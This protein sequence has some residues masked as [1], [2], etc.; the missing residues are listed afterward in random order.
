[1]AKHRRPSRRAHRQRRGSTPR[2]PGP[3]ILRHA[4]RRNKAAALVIALLLV[5]AIAVLDRAGGV[6]PVGDDWRRYHGKSFEVVRVIDGDTLV[7]LVPDGDKPT[8]TVRLW[9]V[10]TPE[11]AKP[12]QQRPA[13][14]LAEEA[15]AFTA[16]RV[17]GQRVMLKLQDH[18]LR[19]RYGR[20]LAYVV[21]QDGSTLNAKLIERGFSE[22]DDRWSHDRA[23][24]FEAL[25][26][27]ARADGRGL[28][29]Q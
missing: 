12:R 6:L 20:V 26:T 3:L 21:L 18:R 25:E 8:T 28:W 24:A 10:D 14:P 7:L 19:G 13:E 27:R 5:I 1:M 17:G 2:N 15:K 29:S 4:L 11:L 9:G 16:R 23:E 22:H